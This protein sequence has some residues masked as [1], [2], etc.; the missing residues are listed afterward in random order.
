MD[1]CVKTNETELTAILISPDRDMAVEFT[2]TLGHSRAFKI[3]SDLKDYPS[4]QALESRLRQLRPDVVFVDVCSNHD[5]AT[6]VIRFVAAHEQSIYAIGLDRSQSSEMLLSALRAGATEFLQSPFDIAIQAE[7][8]ARL[9]RLRSPD[10]PVISQPGIV[11][12]FASCKPG[13]GSSTIAVQT[14]LAL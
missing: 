7:A 11:N 12:A 10:S 8:V 2:S 14:A 13:S 4:R 3:V 5:E 9:R 1:V 6:D